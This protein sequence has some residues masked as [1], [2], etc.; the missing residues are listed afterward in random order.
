MKKLAVYPFD[1]QVRELLMHSSL[2]EKYSIEYYIKKDKFSCA[3]FSNNTDK[4]TEDYK[5][6]IDAVDSVFFAFKDSSISADRYMQ[7]ISYATNNEKEIIVT[8]NLFHYLC[9]YDISIKSY[10]KLTVYQNTDSNPVNTAVN[11]SALLNIDVPIILICGIGEYC[12]K[13]NCELEVRN[14]FTLKNYKVLQ[15]GSKEISPL[16]G[17]NA[18]PS[19]IYSSS[20]S[21]YDRVVGFNKYI[22]A[23]V[24]TENPD[25][26]ILGVDAPILPY[27]NNILNG[28]GEIPLIITTALNIDISIINIYNHNNIAAEYISH[29][30]ACGKYRLNSTYTYVNVSGTISDIQDDQRSLK[31]YHVGHALCPLASLNNTLGEN[32]V[33][34]IDDQESQTELLNTIY[35][36]LTDSL[37]IF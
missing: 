23:K 5:K 18:I 26:I 11:K 1:Y 25:L 6:A 9:N 8:G 3:L 13:F 29:L 2:I 27:N 15:L 17:F 14:F 16:F 33:Y 31:Y 4:I 35:R 24:K 37:D 20:T 28:L 12:N 34:S 30:L 7:V 32:V 19:F 10:A 36:N 21:Y 22:A